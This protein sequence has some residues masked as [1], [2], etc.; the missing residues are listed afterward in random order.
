VGVIFFIVAHWSWTPL[1]QGL[2][3]FPR[4]KEMLTKE[5]ASKLYEI[6]SFFVSQ[7]LAEAPVLLVFPVAFFI[8]IWPPCAL[9]VQVA[10]QVFVMIALNIQVCS[11]MSMLISALCMDAD[12]PTPLPDEQDRSAVWCS[13]CSSQ[14]VEDASTVFELTSR[15]PTWNSAQRTLTLNF[16]GRCNR[17]SSKNF[18]L[19][20]EDGE[21]KLLFG[22]IG[23]HL[24]VLDYKSPFG[25][26]QAF[27]ATLTASYWN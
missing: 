3:N 5:R 11:S 19:Q 27:A 7:V 22:K 17:A 6:R 26:V 2:G 20:A 16:D 13:V 1:F 18:Q 9:P 12:V 8:I 4:E 21:R 24:F 14:H 25:M 23:E 10:M 15:R